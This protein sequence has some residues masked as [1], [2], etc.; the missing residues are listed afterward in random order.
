MPPIDSENKML[1]GVCA[2]LAN[3]WDMDPT[4]LRILFVLAAIF[5]WIVPV[6][7]LYIILAIAMPKE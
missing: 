7:L 5:T 3:A 4:I 6:V 1:F 2:G